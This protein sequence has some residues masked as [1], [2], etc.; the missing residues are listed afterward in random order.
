MSYKRDQRKKNLRR[1]RDFPGMFK[2]GVPVGS[3]NMSK[4][5]PGRDRAAGRFVRY[6]STEEFMASLM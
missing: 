4:T 3:F 2:P 6:R 5:D 1:K